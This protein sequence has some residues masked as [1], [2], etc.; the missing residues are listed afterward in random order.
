MDRQ[1]GQD[2]QDA[3][4]LHERLTPAMIAR[5]FADVQDC[6]PAVSRKNPVHPVHRCE[7]KIHPCSTWNRFPATRRRGL[8]QGR[9]HQPPGRQTRTGQSDFR[10][11]IL[12]ERSGTSGES[13]G[14]GIV[15]GLRK[16]FSYPRSAF[17]G[18]LQVCRMPF[19]AGVIG[20]HCRLGPAAT[21]ARSS[22]AVSL[23]LPGIGGRSPP[24]QPVPQQRPC[25][26]A[27]GSGYPTSV[28]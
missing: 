3:T 15:G 4:L 28:R 8:F 21:R 5:G 13:K 10:G 11:H 7:S 24:C 17:G 26:R 18:T 20:R 12:A 14:A 22:P 6:K 25:R 16:V 2:N 19:G 1:D 23:H 9:T 27:E